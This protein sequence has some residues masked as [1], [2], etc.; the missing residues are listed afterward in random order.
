MSYYFPFGNSSAISVDNINYAFSAISGS[1]ISSSLLIPA[2]SASFANSVQNTPPNGTTGASVDASTC[3]G[4]PDNGDQGTQGPR[5]ALGSDLSYCPAGTKECPG[6]F[7]SLSAVNAAR[8]SGSQF[9]VVCIDVTGYIASTVG[10]PDYLP[11]NVGYT[12]PSIP[13]P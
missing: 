1:V 3:T 8:S 13:E 7:V 12:L 2:L 6:L 11:V 10:C 9:S 4:T 5:G